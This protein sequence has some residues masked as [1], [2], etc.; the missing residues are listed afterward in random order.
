MSNKPKLTN[1]QEYIYNNVLQHLEEVLEGM[2]IFRENS[3]LSIK[4]YAGTGKTFLTKSIVQS[5]LNKNKSIVILTPTHQALDVSR[6]AI[7]ISNSNLHFA[8]LHSFMGLKPE[9]NKDG[10]VSF[11]R[12]RS[13]FNKNAKLEVDVAIIDESSMI[14]Q[15]LYTFIKEAMEGTEY[16][17]RVK[18]VIF[19]GDSAQLM[20]VEEERINKDYKHAIY[21]NDIINEYTLTEIIRNPDLEVIEFVNGVRNF[22]VDKGNKQD[23]FNY[24]EKEKQKEHNKIKFYNNKKDFVKSFIEKNRIKDTSGCIATFTNAKVNAYNKML[25]DYFYRDK[26]KEETPEIFKDDLFVLQEGIV[27]KYGTTLAYNSQILDI[28]EYN[29][30]DIRVGNAELECYVCTSSDKIKFKVLKK[31]SQEKWDKFLKDYSQK[32]MKNR[33]YWKK[34]YKYKNTFIDYKYHYSYTIHKLQG[35]SFDDIWVDMTNLG[36]TDN[37]TLL[38]LFYVACTRS[39]NNVHILI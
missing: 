38:R 20:P 24:I 11:K 9:Y 10:S 21:D 33:D 22:I 18:A 4:G 36:Y 25:R 37:E 35:S 26:Y 30:D 2:D 7:G 39:K 6:E 29:L 14:T 8:T 13:T 1:D 32:C 28:K 19:V 16:K 5:I 23:L 31:S 12:D 15:E 17:S 27:N 3:W 34:Y